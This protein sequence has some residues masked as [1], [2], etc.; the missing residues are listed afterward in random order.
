MSLHSVSLLYPEHPG[1]ADKQLMRRYVELFRDT[2]SCPQ[3]H[4][5]FKVI[6]D[7]YVRAHPDWDSSRFNFFLFVCRAHNTVNRRLNKPKPDS[8]QACLDT[9][10]ANTQHTSA[11]VYRMKYLDYLSRNWSREMSGEGFMHLAQV[12]E[13]RRI[14][15]EYWNRK[16]D[17]S[18]GSFDMNAAVL[19]FIDETPANRTLLTGHARLATVSATSTTIGLKGG[20]FRLNRG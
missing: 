1:E 6:F 12:R 14:T 16:T 20:R 7:N 2:L 5:H 4:N 19:D 13:L 15:E 3:C 18:T 11:L 10:T 17:E 9:F 8:V